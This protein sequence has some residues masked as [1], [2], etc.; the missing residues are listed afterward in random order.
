MVQHEFKATVS[1]AVV[2]TGVD[3]FV[4]QVIKVTIAVVVI[5][6]FVQL[7]MESLVG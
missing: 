7:V 5:V 1:G 3:K 2:M 6:V 4:L